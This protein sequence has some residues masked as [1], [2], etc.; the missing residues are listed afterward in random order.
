M[1]APIDNNVPKT[2]KNAFYCLL[3]VFCCLLSAVCKQNCVV[4]YLYLVVCCV[5]VAVCGDCQHMQSGTTERSL[6]F[7]Y[8]YY[9]MKTC[10]KITGEV[11]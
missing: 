2:E 3:F 4:C 9:G 5:S 8:E 11:E 10:V 1:K 7:P 6:L